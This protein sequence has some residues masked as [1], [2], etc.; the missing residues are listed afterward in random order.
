MGKK[1]FWKIHEQLKIGFIALILCKFV[2]LFISNAEAFL[3]ILI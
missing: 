1:L 2:P 3:T